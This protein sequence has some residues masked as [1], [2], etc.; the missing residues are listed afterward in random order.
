MEHNSLWNWLARAVAASVHYII[1]RINKSLMPLK[2]LIHIL[3]SYAPYIVLSGK[4]DNF[5]ICKIRWWS[6]CL[7]LFEK[8]NL[9]FILEL[10]LYAYITMSYYISVFFVLF[11]GGGGGIQRQRLNIQ[12]SS[13]DISNERWETEQMSTFIA[14][15]HRRFF[16][17][18]RI[19]SLSHVVIIER[20]SSSSSFIVCKYN[21]IYCYF[22]SQWH[23]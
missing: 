2:L 7:T 13:C 3:I 10:V 20:L 4:K 12:S 16:A 1:Q 5:L 19:N 22:F 11:V 9:S 6:F 15:F 23:W 18:I 8:F 14:L 17:W 21:Q